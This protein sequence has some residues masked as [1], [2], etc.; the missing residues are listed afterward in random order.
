MLSMLLLRIPVLALLAF[1]AVGLAAC[2]E[3]PPLAEPVAAMQG[4]YLLDTKDQVRIVVYE[5]P[6]LTNLYEVSQSGEIDMPLID[7]VPARGRT[8]DQVAAT[9]AA[10][11]GSS[12]LV[13]PDVSVE[14]AEYRPFF[15]LGEV[16]QPGQYSYVPGMTVETA[17]ATA[18]GYTDRAN[19]RT[20][21]VSRTLEGAVHESLVPVTAPIHP[22]DTIYV[23]E[24]LL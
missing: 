14:V 22:G 2:N 12:Y 21:R 5:Q 1:V 19:M 11:L 9:I 15:A 8:T 17:I 24:R 3:R 13:D 7:E 18:G 10:R 23:Y 16:G 6:A 4:P 20:V